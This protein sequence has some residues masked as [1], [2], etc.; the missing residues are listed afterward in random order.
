VKVSGRLSRRRPD[1]LLPQLRGQIL[2]RQRRS[3]KR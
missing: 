1:P 2:R 3:R